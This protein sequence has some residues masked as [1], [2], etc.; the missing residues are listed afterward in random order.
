MSDTGRIKLP[1]GKTI[2]ERAKERAAE[3]IEQE[4]YETSKSIITEFA[5]RIHPAQ[6]KW[7]CIGGTYRAVGSSHD[8]RDWQTHV[9]E[10][11]K[12][13]ATVLGAT[14]AE[15]RRLGYFIAQAPA[16]AEL[17]RDFVESVVSN[18]YSIPHLAEEA[19]RILEAIE[20]REV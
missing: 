9:Y 7:I 8:G 17:L 2:N 5:E 4:L 16:M 19:E 3:I 14:A 6:K 12:A 18:Q 10:N 11:G 15:S 13:V 20:G 1:R